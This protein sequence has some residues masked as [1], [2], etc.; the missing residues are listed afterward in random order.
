MKFLSIWYILSLLKYKT[1][2]TM[3][4]DKGDI[5]NQFTFL[6]NGVGLAEACLVPHNQPEC[7]EY[8]Q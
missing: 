4:I 3:I 6:Q 7:N 2:D 5:N 1:S 8:Q